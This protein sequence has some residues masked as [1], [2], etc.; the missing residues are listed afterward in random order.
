MGSTWVLAACGPEVEDAPPSVAAPKAVAGAGRQ[1]EL[2]RL[3]KQAQLRVEQNRYQEGIDLFQRCLVLD[4]DAFAVRMDLGRCYTRIGQF[5]TAVQTFQKALETDPSSAEA[6]YMLGVA[7]MRLGEWEAAIGP[8][9]VAAEGDAEHLQARWNLRMARRQSGRHP[10]EGPAAHRLA[11]AASP[12][13]G[14]EAVRFTDVGAAAGVDRVNMGRGS[15]WRDW[16]GDG[17]LDLFTVGENSLHT[18]YRNR[19]DGTFFEITEEAGLDDRR[20]GWSSLWVDYDNDGGA[21]LFVTRNAWTGRG[22]NSL[23]RNRGDGTFAEVTREAG[24]EDEADSFCA[25]WGDYDRDGWLDLYVANGVSQRGWPNAL[26]RNRGDG[27]FADEALKAGVD[28]QLRHTIGVAW[29]DYD[30][31]AWP[32]LYTVNFRGPNALY[33]NQGDGTFAKRTE[34]AGVAHPFLGFVAF[35]FDFNNDGR[36]DIFV[37]SWTANAEEVIRSAVSGQPVFPGYHPA[38]YRNQGDGTFAEVSQA[39]GLGRTFGSMAATYG[40]IDNDG[41]QDL[42]LAN[43]GP[44]MDRF[45]PDRLLLNNGDETFADIT[46][47]AG[48]GNIGKGHGTTMADFDGDGDLDIYAPQGGMGGNPGDRQPNSLYRNQGNGNHWLAVR[49][50]GAGPNAGLE[51]FSNLDGIGARITVAVQERRLV[52]QVSGGDGF[53]STNSLPVEFG[54]GGATEVAWVE[55]RW[56]SGLV[57]RVEGVSV[58]RVLAVREEGRTR[59]YEAP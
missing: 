17:W 49:A 21:D 7:Y 33:R 5:D 22:P 52:G 34:A 38:L 25:A 28:N 56:P 31:D 53:G 54:L 40:D 10:E 51:Q 13:P 1:D 36:L 4:P 58:D 2:E 26:Y 30:D 35:F 6:N 45:E 14:H 59:C 37:A 20:G 18:L 43:G 42:Y 8:L 19:G 39:A 41:F 32:D 12:P 44:A 15:A 27:T 11:L 16:D 29:G 47:A 48:M 50:L 24:L 9:Q 46:F 55:V 23:Y 3:H 57:D